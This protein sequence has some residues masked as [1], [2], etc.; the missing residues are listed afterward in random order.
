[1]CVK[2]K[3]PSREQLLKLAK[4]D[5]ESLVDLV[6]M[7]W[8][9][10]EA[11]EAEV[12][13]LKRNSRNSSKPPSSD[14]FKPSKPED[15]VPGKPKKRRKQGGQPGHKGHTLR[16]VD[17]PDWICEHR[18][19]AECDDCG[20]SLRRVR[21]KDR[22]WESRQVFD[23]PESITVEVTEHRAEVVPCP[24]CGKNV[25]A[26]FPEEVKAPVQYGEG[27]M[28]L[29][30]Y[31]QT[32]QILPCDRLREFF[33]DVFN[34]TIGNATLADFLERGGARASPVAES[35]KN[36]LGEARFVFSDE[37]GWNLFGKTNW[38]HT[39]ST[40][41][42]TYLEVHEKRGY[43]AILAMGILP[44]YKGWVV[45]DFF[46]SYYKL[47]ECKHSLCNAHHLRDLTYVAESLGQPW[48][49][50][51]I[52]LL[53]E[54]KK[55]KDREQA[56]GRPVGSKT[57]ERLQ[58][59]YFEILKAGYALNPE[60][61]R[62]KGQRGKLKRG[63]ALNLLDRFLNRQEEVMAFL[64]HEMPFDNN[65]AERDLRMMKVKQKI[66]GCFRSR[67]HAQ[68]FARFRSII[69]TARK[70]SINILEILKATL[71]DQRRAAYLLAG[72]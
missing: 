19:P 32:Y 49:S 62:R 21:K 14:H 66:S 13:E 36:Q 52:D 28:A 31:M 67:K 10:V 11:L 39:V 23:L 24:C 6:L 44:D 51:M 15:K 64:I 71:T 30:A 12:A 26:A 69:G 40:S 65:Q 33:E 43:D 59:C 9:R 42:L 37:T 2:K 58:K 53:L 20:A 41:R 63:K 27:I 56:G 55:L 61:K 5:P 34:I 60:P 29:A 70:Q 72:T 16:R 35:I 38:L 7:L 25:K 46:S 18:A 45:H 8:D 50:D 57:L 48:A 17:D 54:A 47:K 1:M 68:S 22:Q 3:R 4:E